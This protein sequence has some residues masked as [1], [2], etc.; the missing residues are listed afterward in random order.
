M[1]DLPAF[2]DQHHMEKLRAELWAGRNVGN[3]SVIVGSGYSRN[4]ERPNGA[5]P[6][7][8]DFRTLAQSMWSE[9]NARPLDEFPQGSDPIEIAAEYEG[10]FG[11]GRLDQFLRHQI[12]D[13]AYQPSRLHRLLV[14]LPWADIFTTNWDT[15]LERAASGVVDRRYVTVP[16][17]AGIV[18]S[19]RPRIVK[20]HGSLPH[21]EPFIVTREDFRRYPTT[22]A[23]FVNTVQQAV[24]ENSLCLLG[25]R[26]DDPNFLAWSGWVRDHLGEAA[27]PIYLVGVL[28]LDQRRRAVLA[29]HRVQPIDLAE[30]FPKHGWPDSLQRHREANEWFLLNLGIGE[31]DPTAWPSTKRRRA[32]GTWEHKGVPLAVPRKVSGEERLSDCLERYPGWLACPV[33]KRLTL[34]MKAAEHWRETA[35]ARLGGASAGSAWLTLLKAIDLLLEHVDLGE[36]R[37]VRAWL[38]SNSEHGALGSELSRRWLGQARRGGYWDLFYES[39]DSVEAAL[40]SSATDVAHIR[41]EEALAAI[42]RL[43]YEALETAVDGWPELPDAHELELARAYGLAELGRVAEAR[44]VA[45]RVLHALRTSVVDVA[46]NLRPYALE[47]AAMLAVDQRRIIG[48]AR[49]ADTGYDR[50]RELD[51]WECNPWTYFRDAADELRQ[52][53]PPQ[54][55]I[56]K[57]FDLGVYTIHS[58]WGPSER[59]FLDRA[60]AALRLFE[61][62]AVSFRVGHTNFYGDLA[63]RAANLVAHERPGLAFSVLFRLGDALKDEGPFGRLAVSRLPDP[64]LAELLAT[65]SRALQSSTLRVAQDVPQWTHRL[66]VAYEV[67]SR[68]VDRLTQSEVLGVVRTGIAAAAAPG[69]QAQLRGGRG[70]FNALVRGF[71]ALEPNLAVTEFGALLDLPLLDVDCPA[72]RTG[73]WQDPIAK[74][75]PILPADASLP[76]WREAIERTLLVVEHGDTKR[77]W[78]AIA[79]LLPLLS[80]GRLAAKDVDLLS[81]VVWQQGDLR[82]ILDGLDRVGFLPT[83]LL[84]LPDEDGRNAAAAL[85]AH[86]L[87]LDFPSSD[88]VPGTERQNAERTAASHFQTIERVLT[89]GQVG[90]TQAEAERLLSLAISWIDAHRTREP[91][92]WPTDPEVAPAALASLLARSVL[93]CFSAQDGVAQA[94]MQLGERLRDDADMLV[95]A[96]QLQRLEVWPRRG[97]LDRVVK[98]ARSADPVAVRASLGAIVEWW[99]KDPVPPDELLRELIV[100]LTQ[101]APQFFAQLVNAVAHLVETALEKL[102]SDHVHRIVAALQLLVERTDVANPE[103]DQW[104]DD[105][106]WMPDAR[107]AATR[108]AANVWQQ[109]PEHRDSLEAWRSAISLDRLPQAR[110]TWAQIVSDGW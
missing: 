84:R 70:V 33:S 31:P 56:T 8:P 88:G 86:F 72:F 32:S 76:S 78:A 64:D 25:F 110:R 99:Q 103:N 94:L 40:T 55:Q 23:P 39:L 102:S 41:R 14:S 106:A 5:V 35:D 50:Y 13:A 68:L 34:E 22:H 2:A 49:I 3:A 6:P 69:F 83:I 21:H 43:D 90:L 77:R 7:A 46:G 95:T 109:F 15:L 9:T 105:P 101:P 93:P 108:L 92:S 11:R 51:R 71:S 44:D 74:I 61:A 57:S 62:F 58:R 10:V 87:G 1:S 26:G 79:R 98:G 66:D 73:A 24:M 97:T 4:A 53:P 17:V 29:R 48:D 82:H 81:A 47:G 38:D 75:A 37:S 85:K 89:E 30:V 63:L 60:Y 96:Y 59:N 52:K 91:E 16:T 27:P 28:D 100:M 42:E 20:L 19:R 104:Y 107:V 65:T 67:R 36:L 54:Y 12:D 18:G 80:S 45:R